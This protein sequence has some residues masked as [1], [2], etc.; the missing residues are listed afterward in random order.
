M[1]Y[2]FEKWWLG[3]CASVHLVFNTTDQSP[4]YRGCRERLTVWALPYVVCFLCRDYTISCEESVSFNPDSHW[5]NQYCVKSEN[6]S[7]LTYLCH[8]LQVFHYKIFGVRKEVLSVVF[9]K[10]RGVI[11]WDRRGTL[12]HFANDSSDLSESSYLGLKK[13]VTQ[14]FSLPK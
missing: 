3:I 5:S 1:R 9:S 10:V 6:F 2:G 12:C 4:V 11:L 7:V 13:R 14:V 8:V